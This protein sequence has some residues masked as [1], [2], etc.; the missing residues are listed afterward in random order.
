MVYTQ[1]ITYSSS[2]RVNKQLKALTAFKFIHI[3]SNKRYFW[4]QERTAACR[5][6]SILRALYFAE[7]FKRDQELVL[8]LQ[9]ASQQFSPV[10]NQ[11]LIMKFTLTAIVSL[12]FVVSALG[13]PVT[14]DTT[15]VELDSRQSCDVASQS[16]LSLS[17]STN[18]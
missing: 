6:V 17:S 12:V 10:L 7:T 8:S 5:V 1:S 11:Y 9:K 15:V 13:T 4:K 2:S 3:R 16:R 14:T 18:F